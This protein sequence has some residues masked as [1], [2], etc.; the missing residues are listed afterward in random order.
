MPK[1]E[2]GHTQGQHDMTL[3]TCGECGCPG[4]LAKKATYCECGFEIVFAKL[5]SGK[6]ICLDARS[7]VFMVRII[8][9]EPEKYGQK[10]YKADFMGDSFMTVHS[11]V[12]RYGDRKNKKVL[13]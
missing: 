8:E 5:E 3:W 1:C 9:G 6:L 10:Q 4:Y 2:C 13:R 11:N 7:Q 12:C